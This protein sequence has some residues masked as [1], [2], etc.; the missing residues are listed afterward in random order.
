MMTLS[1]N[2]QVAEQQM[3]AIIFYLTT[4]GYI[5]G[6][7][8]LSEKKFVSDY[9][10]RVVEWRVEGA[11]IDDPVL[12][13]ELVN[14]YTS[15]FLEV[16]QQIDVSVQELFH[17]VVAEGEDPREFVTA[18]LKLRCLE[19]FKGFDEEN[20]NH[21]LQTVHA[22]VAADGYTH[23]AEKRF[24]EELNGLLSADI[25]LEEDDIA[26]VAPPQVKIETA[27]APAP[28][29]DNHPFFGRIERHYSADPEV[30]REQAAADLEL[31]ERVAA[32][33][34]EQRR[35]GEGKLAGKHN[36]SELAG[37]GPFLDGHVYSLMP[38]PGQA[39]EL[40]VLG[41]LH[42][43]Y[44]CLK[45]AIM[46]SDF[47]RK[48]QKHREDPKNNPAVKL[49][50]LG[51]YIDRGMFS[52]N[53]I[54]RTVLQL[55]MTVPDDVYVLRGNHEY[56]IE[57]NGRVYG[58]VKPAE[59]I[60]TLIG[61]MPQEV[62]EGYMRFFDKLPNMLLF[63]KSLF[64]HAGIPRD[65]LIAEKYRDLSSLNDP[66]IRF[67][68]LWSD[69]SEADFIP[70]ELQK[71]N[72]R[73]PFGRLQFRSFMARLGCNTMVR[74]HEK[75]DA[76]FKKIYDD[77][78]VLLLNLFSAGGATNEDLPPE[79]SYRTVTPMALTLSY[80]DG[81]HTLTPWKIDYQNFNSPVR[82]AFFMHPPEIEFKVG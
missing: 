49:V 15:H 17:E 3:Q 41:D 38:P 82:N 13:R 9:I 77:G 31:L 56:Y 24:L 42:G 14:K 50:F 10:R 25:P 61:H 40:I 36:V 39:V 67:Q 48:V 30:L 53:G 63:D 72:A 76:G 28:K 81:V 4:V 20:Q 22:L 69:P 59:A 73:F 32:K 58:G 64:V 44:S 37:A 8:D 27:T 29:L 12:R 2:P 46:Q 60:N 74:G 18:K 75:V 62:F 23:P 54:L 52:F 71:Q 35:A 66:D 19:I 33:L 78:V 80:K 11:K 68:M 70:A 57:F 1:D 43:C 16:F 5:D 47:M 26:E 79:S 34:D 45:G 65:D 51:D 6:D 21:L 7:F 55:F